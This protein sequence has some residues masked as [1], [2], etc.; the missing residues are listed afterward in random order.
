VTLAMMSVG[1]SP[2]RTY[3]AFRANEGLGQK[4]RGLARAAA[5]AALAPSRSPTRK[6]GWVRFPY[7]HHVFDDERAGFARQLKYFKNIGEIIGIDDAVAIIE[8]ENPI[9]GRYFCLTF[10]DGFKNWI[11]NALPILVEH[12]AVAAFFVATGYIGTDPER[13]RERLLDFYDDRSRLMAFLSWED[14]RQMVAAGM[15][16]GSHSVGHVYLKSLDD[17]VAMDELT[18]S[19]DMI[20]EK[21]GQPCRHFCCPFGRT[22]VDF[23]PKRHP[24]MAAQAGYESFL[25]GHRG[26][27]RPGDSPFDIKRDHLLANWSDHQ[28]RYF[29]G[30]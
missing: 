22:D 9:D 15:T 7:Y 2:I 19:R 14:C 8:S 6:T 11:E 5:I 24:Q 23:D 10:D 30:D 28:L 13:D 21:T 17:N 3:R 4:L 27:N 26:K 16:I 1:S 20:L 25:T 12:Q 29:L 18:I